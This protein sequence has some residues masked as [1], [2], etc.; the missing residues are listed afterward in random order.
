M[1]NP[2]RAQTRNLTEALRLERENPELA[3][4]LKAEAIKG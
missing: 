1:T 3:A 2:Y 4:A